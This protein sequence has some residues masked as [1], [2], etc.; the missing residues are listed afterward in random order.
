MDILSCSLLLDLLHFGQP[1]PLC[2]HLPE[3]S[4]LLQLV[5]LNV[6]PETETEA[7]TSE[8]ESNSSAWRFYEMFF[9]RCIRRLTPGSDVFLAS[10]ASLFRE[11][12][13]QLSASYCRLLL[14]AIE[15]LASGT[16]M[17][18]RRMQR[19]LQPL[20]EIYGQ[21]VSH[22][23]RSHKKSP[24]VYKEFVQQTLSGYAIYLSSCINRAAKQQK[25]NVDEAKLPATADAVQAIDENFRR[26]CKIYIGHSVSLRCACV[27]VCCL[28]MCVCKKLRTLDYQIVNFKKSVKL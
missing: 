24:A 1:L 12:L 26:I 11:Q 15:T 18:A 6:E 25:E 20:L 14:L 3:L 27:C 23:F 7:E 10:C 8:T 13:P 19:H 5:P 16:G 4:Q 2:S 17:Q 22:K 28:F 9:G 21:F